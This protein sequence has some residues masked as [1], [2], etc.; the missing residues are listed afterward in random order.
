ML[1]LRELPAEDARGL[2]SL[3]DFVVMDLAF[4]PGASDGPDNRPSNA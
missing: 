4:P 3:D 1:A 2:P